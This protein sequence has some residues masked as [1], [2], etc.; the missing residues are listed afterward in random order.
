MN[1]DMKTSSDKFLGSPYR[2]GKD[3]QVADNKKVYSDATGT[4]ISPL[5]FKRD[6]NGSPH[7]GSIKEVQVKPRVLERSLANSLKYQTLS[8]GFQ[9]A[10]TLEDSNDQEMKL[11][12]S[13]YTGHRKGLKAENVYAKNFRDSTMNAEKNLRMK[14]TIHS[15]FRAN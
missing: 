9:S 10:F 6:L 8:A 12:I 14:K 7:L 11:P 2:A 13:G 3:R 4:T 5:K 15:N 1:K